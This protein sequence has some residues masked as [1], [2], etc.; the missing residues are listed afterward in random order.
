MNLLQ[1][2]YERIHY[3]CFFRRAPFKAALFGI[4]RLWNNSLDF[5]DHEIENRCIYY[6]H[7]STLP[8]KLSIPSFV[9][10]FVCSVVE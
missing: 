10:H 5:L 8:K 4:S 2:L 1:A 9:K 6:F 3:N 7:E